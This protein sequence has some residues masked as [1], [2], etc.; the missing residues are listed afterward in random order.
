MNNRNENSKKITQLIMD[1]WNI[2]GLDRNN[3]SYYEFAWTVVLFKSVC[4]SNKDF[5]TISSDNS[6]QFSDQSKNFIINENYNFESLILTMKTDSKKMLFKQLEE[7]IFNFLSSNSGKLSNFL[8]STKTFFSVFSTNDDV[9]YDAIFVLLKGLDA[10]NLSKYRKENEDILKSSFAAFFDDLGMS[11]GH[12]SGEHFTP[13]TIS[14]LLSKL[15]PVKDWDN[16][17]DPTCGIGSSLI[18]NIKK[19]NADNVR[20]FGQDINKTT[21]NLCNLNMI[22]NNINDAEISTGDS[23]INPDSFGESLKERFDVIVA[24][25]P[26]AMS[27]KLQDNTY[28]ANDERLAAAGVVA[29][30]S[31]ADFAFI[32][33]MIYSLKRNGKMACVVTPGIFYREGT[34]AKIRKYLVDNNYIESII[35]LPSDLL[36]GTSVAVCILI[37]SKN[38]KSKDILYINANNDKFYEKA[39]YKSKLS[40]DGIEEIV[41]IYSNQKFVE[42]VSYIASFEEI[43]KN[44]YNLNI[45]YYIDLFEESEPV[46]LD[47]I[48]ADIY[49]IQSKL[50][51]VEKK[52]TD[53]LKNL[54]IN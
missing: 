46:D 41:D 53:K 5:N 51:D 45:N 15:A 23:L 9:K 22:F 8:D 3:A 14:M 52:L 12:S 50:T 29:P 26:K 33:H 31:K 34:E 44:N 2:I 19:N 36:Y 20:V 30:K 4:D 47:Q 1:S 6:F 38:K 10:I 13:L 37:I 43:K 7:V 35:M 32:M 48:V 24:D 17:Y 16:L 21:T 11:K 54:S 28:L 25:I 42:K 40:N 49:E 27:W 39:T 18:E